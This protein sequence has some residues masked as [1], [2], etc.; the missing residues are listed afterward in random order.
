MIELESVCARIPGLSREEVTLWVERRW[1]RAEA[2]AASGG[3][4]RFTEMDL[5]RVRLVVE[6]RSTLEVDEETMPLVL[7]LVDQL[8]DARRTVKALLAGL[9]AQPDAVREAVLA[10]A[11][12]EAG[13]GAA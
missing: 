9:D 2:P 4:W 10:A 7:S 3:E 5:A 8:Y 13:Q 11:R 1:I 6:L 12:R